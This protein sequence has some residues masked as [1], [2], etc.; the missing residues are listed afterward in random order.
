MQCF[1]RTHK[2]L[3]AFKKARQVAVLLVFIISLTGC[4]MKSK[5]N[6]NKASSPQPVPSSQTQEA[7]LGGGCFWCTEAIFD[8]L[9]GVHEVVSGYAGGT[10][11]SPTYQDVSSGKSGH[12]EVIKVRFEPSVIS[13][14]DIL[15]VFFA[16]HDPTSKDRQG[17]DI[18]I[19]Y[20]SVIFYQNE[21]QKKTAIAFME[22]E[23][24]NYSKPI[25][26]ELRASAPFYIAESYHQDYYE[27]N[28]KQP[29]CSFVIKPKIH[30]I[31]KLFKDKLK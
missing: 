26:T 19:Q 23:R 16:S 13:Y 9:K 1:N 27:L 5:T 28:Q 20:R 2:A 14:E 15:L 7:L 12:I 31:E 25:L 17:N 3:Q 22:K 21:D 18:G 24:T 10:N 29:Y 6:S 11:S 8:R 30:K 4:F